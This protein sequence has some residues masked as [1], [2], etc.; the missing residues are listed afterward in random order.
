MNEEAARPEP[1]RTR[2]HLRPRPAGLGV[3]LLMGAITL[4]WAIR[5]T[6][7]LLLLALA[8]GFVV[9]V[10]GIVA[11][12]SAR[13]RAV[14][15]QPI[16]VPHAGEPTRWHLTVDGLRRPITLR[17]V[18]RPDHRG[19]HVTRADAGIITLPPFAR[20]VIH[21][22]LFDTVATGGVG[23]W[24][25]TRRHRTTFVEPIPIIPRPAPMPIRWP[26][27]RSSGFAL[28]DRSLRGDD[29]FR[30]IRP[31]VRGDE[32]RRIHWKSTA[33]HGELMV[34][35]D[36]GTGVVALQVLLDPGPPGPDADRIVS[37]A[38][39]LLE[40][41]LHRG[42]TVQLVTTEMRIEPPRIAELGRPLR[43]A[44]RMQPVPPPRF[45]VVTTMVRHSA[46]ARRPLAAAGAA[47][48]EIPPWH[49][50]SCVLD[51]RGVTWR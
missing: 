38:G 15:L 44:P 5:N 37:W 40:T 48:G 25:A 7:P 35:E 21:L 33:R 26:E 34:R 27:P 46:D 23:L 9:I 49:G 31:Y 50:L 3:L 28:E 41:A 43:T 32:R 19:W 4:V 45:E 29:L 14:V 1:E 12:R 39:W 20:G 24:R 47:G 6:T 22:L 16:G 17:S 8:L 11:L 30:G 51:R 10:D 42:W 13:T 18:E 36:E 2:R